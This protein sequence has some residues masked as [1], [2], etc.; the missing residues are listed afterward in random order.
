MAQASLTQS[1]NSGDSNSNCNNTMASYNLNN[2]DE[3]A[4]I[5]LWLSLLE[6]NNRH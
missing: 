4:Q 6:P 5:M 2:S 3:D 1:I